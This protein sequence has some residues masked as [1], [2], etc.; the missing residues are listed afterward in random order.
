M[1]KLLNFLN[2]ASGIDVDALQ[3]EKKKLEQ[4]AITLK[5]KYSDCNSK[6]NTVQTE[7]QQKTD[8]VGQLQALLDAN[9]QETDRLQEHIDEITG[10][11]QALQLLT[12]EQKQMI[13]TSE[14]AQELLVAEKNEL[15]LTQKDLQE[16]LQHG[17]RELK[18]L[19][20]EKESMQARLN[21]TQERINCLVQE[22][23]HGENECNQL[24]EQV[25]TLEH[26]IKE[27]EARAA[28]L[29][30]TVT[31][32]VSQ[33]QE[34]Q[35][36]SDALKEQMAVLQNDSEQ[37][38]R[39]LHNSEK[40]YGELEVAQATL[41]Q[42]LEE[43]RNLLSSNEQERIQ[44]K[45]QLA[46]LHDELEQAHR[47][48]TDLQN[49]ISELELLKEQYEADREQLQG[50]DEH[51]RQELKAV[52]EEKNQTD[53]SL[54]RVEQECA[55]LKQ[56]L[57][58]LQ[59]EY[60]TKNEECMQIKHVMEMQSGEYA[61]LQKQYR[62][63]TE[64]TEKLQKELED[65][66][67]QNLTMQERQ[68][69]ETEKQAVQANQPQEDWK[70][71]W[72]ELE[73]KLADAQTE[74]AAFREKFATMERERVSLL[75]RVEQ[76]Q[77]YC[78]TLEQQAA[79]AD[80]QY[81]DGLYVITYGHEVK[82]EVSGTFPFGS[83]IL[84]DEGKDLFPLTLLPVK[85]T[86]VVLPA[87]HEE[88]TPT[89]WG[90]ALYEALQ[91]LQQLDREIKLTTQASLAV[92]N[93]N[94]GIHP[95]LLI[96][97]PAKNLRI[98]VHIDEL[99]EFTT[100]K[101]LHYKNSIDN[102]ID[103]LYTD[104]GWVVMR[105]SE[106]QVLGGVQQVVTYVYNKLFELTG[107]GRFLIKVP[108]HLKTAK[109]T[110]EDAIHAANRRCRENLMERK[111]YLALCEHNKAFTTFKGELPGVDVLPSLAAVLATLDKRPSGAKAL[112]LTS[113]PY[114]S[115][116]ILPLD[117]I[118]F[119]GMFLMGYDLITGKKCT[120][121]IL[122]VTELEYLERVFK[123]NP[124]VFDAQAFDL[125]ALQSVLAEAIC[126]YN[127]VEVHYDNGKG[128]SVTNLYWAAFKPQTGTQ[129]SLPYLHLFQTLLDD[130]VDP[131]LL[132]A[133]S[134]QHDRAVQFDIRQ[135]RQIQ[136]Y[137]AFVTSGDGIDALM[138]GVYVAEL[139]AQLELAEL[140][141]QNIP[142]N[143]KQLPVVVANYAHLCVMKGEI[144]KAADLYLSIPENEEIGEGKSWQEL[145]KADFQDLIRH[146]AD[147]KNFIKVAEILADH[148]WTF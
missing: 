85:G 22:K 37:L 75:Q 46:A 3:S 86:K 73:N 114:Y 27:Q 146:H 31:R 64:T 13:Q 49:K 107:D 20:A 14:R 65:L 43:N 132:V 72:S 101:P 50:R 15:L 33:L 105:F 1:N 98:A 23:E 29:T 60:D 6:L 138:A 28:E 123:S 56:N 55:A 110:R 104:S 24:R 112:R 57:A 62:N 4:L 145:N 113:M 16:N 69:Q 11:I 38:K 48:A 76:L 34:K 81:A 100:K 94:Y 99:Y 126:N 118:Q 125:D 63:Q 70:K 140:L 130:A 61:A 68:Q 97:W 134:T 77:Q 47:L 120:T 136:V 32:Y 108:D 25:Q 74:N 66:R 103:R 141:Y 133:M 143:F 45:E 92:P 88:A 5:Q 93:R 91:Q 54:K 12:D 42:E 39:S 117:K 148:N 115:Q 78:N 121:S 131:E 35:Q 36:E 127:P 10:R 58:E 87:E 128:E 52:E 82:P 96:S 137:D 142:G 30:Q 21:E 51:W 122:Q 116:Q 84:N 18:A 83:Y 41:K 79:R 19:Q 40:A 124:Y 44:L 2:K 147:P 89:F 135:I 26:K 144:Q 119:D 90:K 59:K 139:K 67:Q 7:L 9:K 129:V 80:F 111:V 71:R 106:D 53:I 8:S 17:E 102:I 109:W 95:D